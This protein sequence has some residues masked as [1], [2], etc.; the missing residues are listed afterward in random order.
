MRYLKYYE[1]KQKGQGG[2]KGP[3][4]SIFLDCQNNE[5]NTLKRLSKTICRC[6]IIPT[7]YSTVDFHLLYSSSYAMVFSGSLF[8]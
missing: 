4:K 3:F 1:K 2:Q 8:Q 5:D 7:G 6:F